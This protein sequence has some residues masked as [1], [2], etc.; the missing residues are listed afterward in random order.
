MLTV[1]DEYT[2]ECLEM[3]VGKKMDSRHVLETFDE[4]KTER[5]IP[6]YTRSDNGPEFI[7]EMLRE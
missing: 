1:V 6:G 2:R 4:L 5:G 7:A 3:R